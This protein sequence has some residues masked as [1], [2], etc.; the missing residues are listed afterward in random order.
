MELLIHFI[1]PFTVL[2]LLGIR[3]KKTFLFSLL[4]LTPDF[5]V[6]FHIHRSLSHS[7]FVLLTPFILLLPFLWR[8]RLQ[9]YAVL[10]FLVVASHP[11]LDMFTGYT[12]IFWPLYD[13]SLW[14]VLESTA[15]LGSIPNLALNLKILTEPTIFTYSETFEGVLFTSQGII[16]SALLFLTS[17][18]KAKR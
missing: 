3:F 6:F 11:F 9:K 17:L 15:K 10:A 12:P 13:Q 8:F 2:M 1:I 14:V 18:V 7:I 5:D 16:V 4:A